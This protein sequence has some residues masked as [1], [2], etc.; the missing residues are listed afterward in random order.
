MKM[1]KKVILMML[2]LIGA[3]S[4]NAQVR[5]GGTA[6]ADKAIL[7]LNASNTADDATQGLALPRAAALPAA[8]PT[9]DGVLI[10]SAG[11]V[12]VSKAGVW[13]K[14][15][16]GTGGDG[17]DGGTDPVLVC[18]D[19][20][21]L[22]GVEG[23]HY[24]TTLIN[25]KCWMAENLR[26]S[27]YADGTTLS[28]NSS[29]FNWPG[30]DP[31]KVES[32]GLQYLWLA[33]NNIDKTTIQNVPGTTIVQTQGI[34][35]NNWHVPSEDE[36]TSVLGVTGDPVNPDWVNVTFPGRWN[37]AVNSQ[38]GEVECYWTSTGKTTTQGTLFI[39]NTPTSPTIQMV[40]NNNKTW[41]ANVRCVED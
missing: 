14:L 10:Y 26:D 24:A 21:Y 8:A 31:D 20:G 38:V 29:G 30:K 32:Q 17:G 36:L 16:S 28:R 3:V 15:G 23:T 4:V 39:I 40:V 35:P 27:V 1:K 5:I 7:D 12:Y 6:A 19:D 37:T 34:C 41:Q 25:G 18:G 13:E 9:I 2:L 22:V 11:D 33:A